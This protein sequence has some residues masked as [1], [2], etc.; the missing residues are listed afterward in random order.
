MA[1][2]VRT[3]EASPN[4]P[5]SLGE[6]AAA[7]A[8]LEAATATRCI[9]VTMGKAGAALWE[10]GQVV[11]ARAPAVTV[12]DTVGA[13]DAFM[14]GLMMG[15]TNGVDRPTLLTTACELGAFVA[16]RDGATPPF[17]P[18]RAREWK[19]ALGPAKA[20]GSGIPAQ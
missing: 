14:A 1:T 6:L 10:D 11:H 13:G 15:V 19:V 17:P 5:R 16:S 7:C 4:P 3:G 8:T 2:Y 18:E 20:T 9:C 12:R